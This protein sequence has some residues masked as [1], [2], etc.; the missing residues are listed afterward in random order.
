M[1]TRRR[2]IRGLV[3]LCAFT[4]GTTGAHA[5]DACGPTDESGAILYSSRDTR[6]MQTH[7]SSNDGA[8]GLVWLKRSPNVRGIIGFDLGC[9]QFP[10]EE[11]AC[12]NL[13]LTIYDGQPGTSGS[14]YSAHRMNTPWVEG[15]G[16]FNRFRVNSQQLG[17][18]PGS[19]EGTTWDCRIDTDLATSQTSNCG[20]ADRWLGG[21][22]C[23][24]STCYHLPSTD[25]AFYGDRDQAALLFDVTE[26]VRAGGSDVSWMLKVR[27]EE[28]KSGSVKFYT[29][30]G[31]AFAAETDPD[32]TVDPWALAPRL[33]I[34]R[35]IG[36]G[37][38]QVA[39]LEPTGVAGE[40]TVQVRI[41]QRGAAIGPSA[42]WSNFTG[43]QSGAMELD[44]DELWTAAIPLEV[45]NNEIEFTV[46]NLCG[47]E[48]R[49]VFEIQY[50]ESAKCG[51]GVVSDG[52][53][54]DDGNSEDG[55]CCS[56]N[57]TVEPDGSV[58]LDANACN[59]GGTCGAGVCTAEEV[60]PGSCSG[61]HLC[62]EV[63]ENPGRRRLRHP[64]RCHTRKPTGTP[65]VR[66]APGA[67]AVHA[68]GPRRS[69]CRQRRSRPSEL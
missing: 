26:D 21:D 31:S 1:R 53:A 6:V 49:E 42:H 35:S 63:V 32:P 51:D 52:E 39:L 61:G 18:F 8:A 50:V 59:A 20:D 3:A 54:C 67:I 64:A 38:T 55:D 23:N 11:I 60:Q 68:R 36:S 24:G 7:R 9:L 62:Y 56:A 27:D 47:S 46:F 16:S 66:R 14:W 29:R 30:N 10:V 40:S 45:G 5:Q 13:E 22:D 12:A 44:A 48:V 69:G 19:G 15:N 37:P 25:D 65:P 2:T 41:E 57:C 17:S 34:E 43:G 58:C 28:T 4:L 33:R